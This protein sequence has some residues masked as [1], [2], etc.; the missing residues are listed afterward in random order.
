M[1]KAEERGAVAAR[2]GA[3]S[4]STTSVAT[5]PKGKKGKAASHDPTTPDALR[6]FMLQRWKPQSKKPTARMKQADAFAAR[7]R[8]LSKLFPA[9]TLVVP[10]GHEKL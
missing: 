8:A 7:R 4:T 5:K 2:Q 9:E 6:E 3:R 10:T 1:S